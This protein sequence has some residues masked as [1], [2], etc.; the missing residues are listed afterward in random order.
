MDTDLKRLQQ[1]LKNLL[2]NAI[3]FTEHGSVSLVVE[4]ARERLERG[5][6]RSSAGASGHRVPG[7]GHRHRHPGRQA[8]HHLR[9]VSAGRRHDEPEVRRHRPRAVDQPRNRAAARR[10]DPAP[11]RAG[12]RQHVHALPAGQFR[13]P[14]A[15]WPDAIVSGGRRSRSRLAEIDESLLAQS[16]V[17]DD[18]DVICRDGQGGPGRRE[19]PAVHAHPDGSRPAKRASSAWRRCAATSAW[20]WRGTT[21][22][23]PSRS[24]STCRG[25][26]AGRSST[27]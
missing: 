9:G 21:N 4:P 7:H 20:R 15:A 8:P 16:E 2:S 24:T 13:G 10:R 27:G 22:P 12:R 26:T 5:P 11:E 25:W 1:V 14:A 19:R 18:R 6:S 23:T 17:E 3:K